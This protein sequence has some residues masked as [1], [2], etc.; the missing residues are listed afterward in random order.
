MNL[1]LGLGRIMGSTIARLRSSDR[2]CL[3]KSSCP[4]STF[5][6]P[7][8]WIVFKVIRLPP[9]RIS[10]PSR[11]Q[12]ITTSNGA[13]ILRGSFGLSDGKGGKPSRKSSG[14]ESVLDAEE[15]DPPEDEAE[16]DDEPDEPGEP[17]DELEG[18]RLDGR[19]KPS[20]EEEAFE[21]ELDELEEPKLGPPADV[22]PLEEEEPLDP[23]PD[24]S[25]A[26]EGIRLDE[27]PDI[28]PAGF[29]LPAPP[30]PKPS[31]GSVWPAE[32][33]L[34]LLGSAGAWSGLPAPPG[35]LARSPDVEEAE[36]LPRLPLPLP[37]AAPKPEPPG[38]P[39][40]APPAIPPL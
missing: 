26:W 27:R 5:D 29:W 16:L 38:E 15:G 19:P 22:D 23:P 25:V 31:E 12:S 1:T 21:E 28:V 10:I 35:L 8:A 34:V 39:E 37:E 30:P 17:L 14:G 7:P 9:G 33:G 13:S 32:S 3:V 4:L 6:D 20:P 24:P 11:W 36:G 2:R 18:D 40:P